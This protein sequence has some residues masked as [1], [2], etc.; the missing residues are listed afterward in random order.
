MTSSSARRASSC[1]GEEAELLPGLMGDTCCVV[2]TG[3]MAGSGGGCIALVFSGRPECIVSS[4]PLRGG[5]D[6]GES[7]APDV[8][9]RGVSASDDDG[10]EPYGSIP[11][12]GNV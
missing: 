4:T 12:A 9:Y 2:V 5:S 6:I 7:S 10:G 8:T 11:S 3:V 1:V